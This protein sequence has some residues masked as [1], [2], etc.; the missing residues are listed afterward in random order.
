LVDKTI[1]M[2]LQIALY[3]ADRAGITPEFT[4]SFRTTSLQ[5]MYVKEL[6][7]KG[8]GV[9]NPGTSAHEAGFSLDVNLNKM[10]EGQQK[11]FVDIMKDQGFE[12][13]VSSE[14]WHFTHETGLT[15]RQPK[16]MENQD[17]YEKMSIGLMNDIKLT[18]P[19]IVE[20]LGGM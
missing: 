1:E 8:I 17:F 11:I 19:N 2:D 7:P 10:T 5:K 16:I 14:K 15:N 18:Q 3:K 6:R 9:D 4:E 13:N 12:R 20:D